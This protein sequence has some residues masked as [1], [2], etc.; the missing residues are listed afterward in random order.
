MLV[1]RAGKH[2]SAQLLVQHVSRGGE[3]LR[4]FLLDGAALLVPA[5][6][7]IEHAAHARGFDVERNVDVFGR[8]REQ[9]LGQ[10]LAR[11]GVEISA[12]HAA[13]VAS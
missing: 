9:I 6:L 5:L 12:H 13:D 4:H 3:I 1:G 2:D 8:H 7:S 11:V 10:A